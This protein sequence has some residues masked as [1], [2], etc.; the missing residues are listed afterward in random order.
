MKQFIKISDFSRFTEN[1][2][3]YTDSTGQKYIRP[4]HQ[5]AVGYTYSVELAEKHVDERFPHIL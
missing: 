3:I 1:S 4:I 2:T 5:V